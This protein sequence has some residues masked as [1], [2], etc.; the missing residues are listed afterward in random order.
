MDLV[1]LWKV[2]T[3]VIPIVVGA[4]GTAPRPGDKPEESRNNDKCR[5]ASEDCVPWNSTHTQTG[6]RV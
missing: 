4:L 2:K 6:T 3:K 5:V 1:R